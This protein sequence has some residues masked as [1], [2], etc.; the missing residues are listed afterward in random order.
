[1]RRHS[2]GAETGSAY[3]AASV[4]RCVAF[5]GVMVSNNG[6]VSIPMIR[7]GDGGTIAVRFTF[8]LK[9]FRAAY[10]VRLLGVIEK[11]VTRKRLLQLLA[12]HATAGK[13]LARWRHPTHGIVAPYAFILEL[14]RH[15]EIDALTFLMLDKAAHACRNWLAAGFD[16]TPSR[17]TSR[18]LRSPILHWPTASPP[19]SRLPALSRAAW[20]WRSPKSPR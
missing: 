16:L 7:M 13:A 9:L 6:T 19:A 8:C 17:S 5:M 12:A 14:E 20:C 18:S 2:S 15:N 1:M 10:G 11:P 4:L 3:T